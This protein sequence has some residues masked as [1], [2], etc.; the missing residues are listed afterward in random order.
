MSRL[1]Y[2]AFARFAR[3]GAVGVSTLLFDL[4]LLAALT[5]LLSIPYYYS[6]PLAF[7]VAVSLNYAISSR[8]VFRGS[9]RSIHHS[10]AYFILLAGVGAVFITYGVYVLV[11]YA[12]LQYLLARV[13]VAGVVGLVNYLINLHLN[14][15]VAGMHR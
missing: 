12:H 2:P 13:A 6:T 11:T 10:Y 15:R 9:D 14:F 3:Y 1:S 4:L 7:L 5:Q 8:F